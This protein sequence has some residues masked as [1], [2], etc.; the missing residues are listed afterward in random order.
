MSKVFYLCGGMGKFGKERFDESN[1]WR[2]DIKNQVEQISEGKVKCCNPNQHFNFL[3]DIT[4]KSTRE[5]MEYDLYRVRHSN[6]IIV[7]FNDPNSIGSA[8]E[9]AI[10]YELK[11]PIIGLCEN[12]EEKLLH[13][14]LREFCNRIFTDREE[15]V[16]YLVQHYMNED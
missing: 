1:E 2:V 16:L 5:I 9:M 7:N 11:I 4:D 10:A 15:L 8:C 3:D 6:A 12:R 14:W 13:P